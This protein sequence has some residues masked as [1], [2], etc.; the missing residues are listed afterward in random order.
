MNDPREGQ[1]WEAQGR[2]FYI[3]K[4]VR[5]DFLDPKFDVYRCLEFGEQ[6]LVTEGH[7]TIRREDPYNVTMEPF[8]AIWKRLA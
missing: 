3:V 2:L 6:T 7:L 5:R 8:N 4:V 1:L